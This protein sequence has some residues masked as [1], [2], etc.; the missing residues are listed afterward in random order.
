MKKQI[1]K[2]YK[3]MTQY[4]QRQFDDINRIANQLSDIKN[5]LSKLNR[6]KVLEVS[7]KALEMGFQAEEHPSEG[8]KELYI[9]AIEDVIR[10]VTKSE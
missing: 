7:L 8:R 5:L 6:S 10:T 2:T 9:N 4:E 3:I 1:E